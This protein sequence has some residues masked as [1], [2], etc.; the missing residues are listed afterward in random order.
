MHG[1]TSASRM[2]SCHGDMDANVAQDITSGVPMGMLS[3]T[4][5]PFVRPVTHGV[6]EF[7][8]EDPAEVTAARTSTCH[9]QP[10]PPLP[11]MA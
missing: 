1:L 11:F 6:Q 8:A 4:C 9:A 7:P 5:R 3:L 2:R 10:P